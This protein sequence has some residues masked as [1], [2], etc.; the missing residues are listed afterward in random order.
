MLPLCIRDESRGHIDPCAL[1]PPKWMVSLPL[2]RVL[3]TEAFTS[4]IEWLV[5][6]EVQ[7]VPVPRSVCFVVT[8]VTSIRTGCSFC[9]EVLGEQHLVPVYHQG[10]W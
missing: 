10:G 1:L 5:R 6:T 2:I 3:K 4:R 9:T 7:G 8:E